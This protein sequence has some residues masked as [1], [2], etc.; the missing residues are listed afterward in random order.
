MRGLAKLVTRYMQDVWSDLWRQ[1]EEIKEPIKEKLFPAG[2][3]LNALPGEAIVNLSDHFRV[4][5]SQTF[6]LRR[7]GDGGLERW[8]FH[9]KN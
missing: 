7:A 9:P 3:Q 1:T 8:M 5:Q 2:Y 4:A 6:H